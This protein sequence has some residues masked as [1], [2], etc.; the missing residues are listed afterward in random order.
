[1]VAIAA[2]VVTSLVP[3]RAGAARYRVAAIAGRRAAPLP[4]VATLPTKRSTTINVAWKADVPG[5]GWS[6]P[7][8]WG[9]QVI[10]T[11]PSGPARSLAVAGDLRQR[12]RRRPAEAG[13]LRRPDHGEA[14][15]AR[16]RV[17]AGSRRAAVHGLQL[18]PQDR[19][20]PLV[21]GGAQGPADRRTS[22]QEHLRVGDSGYRRRAHLRA[23]RQH[24]VVLLLDGR[25]AAVDAR[26]PAAAALSRLR[27]RGL[28]GRAR[29]P[30]VFPGR[31][32]GRLAPG[33]ARRENRRGRLE[34]EAD[35]GGGRPPRGGR[36]PRVRTRRAPR[37]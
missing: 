29:R 32:R 23:L 4:P 22:S 7:I 36:R 21:G 25:D 15:P 10:G 37:S 27:H 11:P 1:M 26:H 28:A 33:G 13:A 6:S 3:A 35:R 19:R 31:Q 30:R 12:L 18:R 5:R 20:G 2:L 24:R 9:D 17:A 34:D 14:P 8:V 16:S